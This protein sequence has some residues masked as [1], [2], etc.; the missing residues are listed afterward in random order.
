LE[1]TK[2]PKE[3][4]RAVNLIEEVLDRVNPTDWHDEWKCRIEE[5]EEMRDCLETTLKILCETTGWRRTKE[6]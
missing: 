2:V 4:V 3:V 6:T 5:V 1:R